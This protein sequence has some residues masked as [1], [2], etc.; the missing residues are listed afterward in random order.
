MFFATVSKFALAESSGSSKSTTLELCQCCSARSAYMML[1]HTPAAWW[2]SLW[3]TLYLQYYCKVNMYP[4]PGV[5]YHTYD[6][7][8][9]L[10]MFGLGA[11]SVCTASISVLRIIL[12]LAE[13]TT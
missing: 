1:H 13:S 8:Q 4:V 3:R 5:M 7:Y 12:V 2:E 6:T 9:V 11:G 10:V